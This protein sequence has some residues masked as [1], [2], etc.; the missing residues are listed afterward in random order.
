MLDYENKINQMQVISGDDR[1]TGF[2]PTGTPITGAGWS[3]ALEE[4]FG[5]DAVKITWA[6]EI[7]G[8][9]IWNDYAGYNYE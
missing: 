6:R 1:Y 9:L 2:A 4:N 8:G 3:I 7:E 5:T